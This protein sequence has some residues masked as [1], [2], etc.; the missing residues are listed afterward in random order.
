[1]PE[2]IKDQPLQ[3]STDG[4]TIQHIK[5]ADV[6]RKKGLETVADDL[7]WAYEEDDVPEDEDDIKETVFSMLSVFE[8][9]DALPE[10]F[11]CPESPLTS[12]R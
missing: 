9:Q 4:S 3:L 12:E 5:P 1:M 7:D 2:V 8:P 6:L 11:K 10:E